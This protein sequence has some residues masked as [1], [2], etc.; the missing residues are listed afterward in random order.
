MA[1]G[2]NSNNGANSEEPNPLAIGK[3]NKPYMLSDI[4]ILASIIVVE[5]LKGLKYASTKKEGFGMGVVE[6]RKI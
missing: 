3:L 4:S 1:N 2:D 5:Y 6:V